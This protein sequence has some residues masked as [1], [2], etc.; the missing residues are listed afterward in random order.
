M[1]WPHNREVAS[2]ECGDPDRALPLGHGDHGSI[3]PA[4]PQVSVGADQV[5]DALPVGYAEIGHL[6]LAIG[7]GRIQGGFRLRAELPVDQVG[8][9][10]DDH[11]RG[12]QGTLV[13]LQQLPAG[14]VVLIGAIGRRDQR[15]VSTIS[16]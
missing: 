15:P 10:R 11:G 8:G 6:Q 16:T 9:L 7:N 4:E 14:L 13:A 2:V 5:L 1:T 12:D 3:G